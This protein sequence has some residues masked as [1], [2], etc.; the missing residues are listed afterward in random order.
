MSNAPSGRRYQLIVVG[1]GLAGSEV[2]HHAAE[3]GLDTLLVTTSLDTVCN[4]DV[5]GAVLTPPAGTLLA[6]LY[7]ETADPGGYATT[8][9]LHR[10][11]KRRLEETP[12]L[13]LLQSNVDA[14]D[15]RDGVVRGVRT[16][17]G[18]PRSGDR[19]VLCVGSFLRARLRLG[20]LTESAGRLGEMSYDELHDDL[21]RHGFRLRELQL[22]TPATAE[23]PGYRVACRVVAPD[24]V[25]ADLRLPRLAGLHG[26]GLCVAGP[27]SYEETAR[28]GRELGRRLAEAPAR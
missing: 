13:H 20:R 1:A 25:T 23:R 5:A 8:W 21:E 16:W 10:A 17:E 28:Q 24:E 7:A 4:L 22:D 11:A 2:A 3:A 14:L 15:V 26:A 19:V 6:D 9:D 12:R 27:Q 18:V